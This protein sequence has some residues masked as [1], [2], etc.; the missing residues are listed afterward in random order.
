MASHK[1]GR[2]TNIYTIN[3]EYRENEI[4]KRIPISLENILN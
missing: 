2:I 3:K 4:L 1:E